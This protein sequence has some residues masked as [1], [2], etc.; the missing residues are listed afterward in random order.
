MGMIKT[1]LSTALDKFGEDFEIIRQGGNI[2][3][4]GKL[5]RVKRVTIPW[6]MQHLKDVIFGPEETINPNDIIHNKT[7]DIYFFIYTLHKQY[8]STI[9]VAQVATLLDAD[10]LCDIQRLDG[11]TGSFGGTKQ[12]FQNQATDVR[13]HIREIISDMRVERP[14]LLERALVLLYIRNTEDLHVLDRIVID[15]RNYQVEHINKTT[16]QGLIEAQM[17]LDKR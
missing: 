11:E 14:A 6:A 8:K 4:K 7:Q 17:S 12:T 5:G 10:S 2:D 15:S 1:K 3:L 13:Y 9:L 16:F